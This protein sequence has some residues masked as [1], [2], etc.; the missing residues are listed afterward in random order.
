MSE[1]ENERYYPEL[2]NEERYLAYIR[3]MC[4]MLELQVSLK[5]L[6]D[7]ARDMIGLGLYEPMEAE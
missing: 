3:N 4:A 2:T 5:D 6:D 1:Y 7:W